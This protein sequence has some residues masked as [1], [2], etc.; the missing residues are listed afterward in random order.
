MSAAAVATTIS[1]AASAE[2]RSR[3]ARTSRL[4]TPRPCTASRTAMFLI[5]IR[6]GRS[7]STSCV[8]GAHDHS[9]L[10]DWSLDCAS[11]PSPWARRI[12]YAILTPRASAG[13]PRLASARCAYWSPAVPGSS[14]RTSPTCSPPRGT[15]RSCSTRCCPQ[16]H[17]GGRRPG[18]RPARAGAR[19]RPRRRPAGPAAARGRRGLPPG[20]DGRARRRPGGR[21]R[22]RRAQRPRHRGA[23]RRDAR[24]RDRAG[25][26]WP[27]RWSSTARAATTAPSTASCG[28][29]RAG[30]SRPRRGPV[31]AAVPALRPRPR[32]RARRRGRAARPAQHVRRHA[33]SP[34]STWPRRGRGRPAARSWSLRY[35]N[36]YGPR[37]PRDTPYAGVASIF[38][39]ALERGRGAA[40]VRGRPPAARLRARHATWPRPTCCAL[41]TEP[42]AGT[43]RRR[44]TSARASRTPI[45]DLAAALAAAIGRPRARGRRRRPAGR[46]AAR[47]RRPGPGR[48]AARASGPRCGFA[49]GVRAFATDPLRAP[50]RANRR[51]RTVSGRGPSARPS[52]SEDRDVD[53]DPEIILPCLDEADALPVVL[54]A[55][56]A[57]WPGARRGQRLHRRHRRR[58]R[59]ALGA[60]V[61][62]EPRRGY[63]AAVHAGLEAAAGRAGRGARRRRLARSRR[64]A[65]RWPLRS[66]RAQPTSR[67]GRRV[68]DAAGAWPWHARA[69]NAA[70]RRDAAAPR[71]AGARPRARPGGAPRRAAR[72]GRRRPGLRL[73]AGAAAAGRRGGLA[74]PRGARALPGPGRRAGRRC[75][76]RCAARCGP[77]RDMAGLLR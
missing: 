17:G 24:R 14:A 52:P 74:D 53:V 75:P 73:P 66:L 36:V 44:S 13:P 45:G 31:R 10:T 57:G 35:H 69:G 3:A 1:S 18:S 72:P 19:R 70:D 68:P 15:S 27:A 7:V 55:L 51:H 54:A 12:A 77:T 76:G 59:R 63:G 25:W 47:R 6:P 64:A 23:A 71:R 56:P 39:S 4:P 33:S 42:P 29:G 8:L 48:R 9:T 11:D 37:M 2:A 40:G 16:A 28:P 65:R 60:R 61:V 26:C 32:A 67:V 50:A 30:P 38:R 5:S 20:R 49:E 22:L 43:A 34:R 46:R 21:A 62:T 41:T 58:S